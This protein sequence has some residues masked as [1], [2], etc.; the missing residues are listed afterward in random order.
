MLPS[1][2]PAGYAASVRILALL[3]LAMTLPSRADTVRI[4]GIDWQTDY[5]QAVQVARREGKPL[6]LHF[7]ENPG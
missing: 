4:G 6:W 5:D 2:D 1:Y 7:G 3:L